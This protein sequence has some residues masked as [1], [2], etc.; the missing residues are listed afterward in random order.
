M[1]QNKQNN[2]QDSWE[3]GFDKKIDEWVEN[4]NEDSIIPTVKQFIK[5]TL[6]E[7]EE[8]FKFR[9]EQL[10]KERH[11]LCEQQIKTTLEELEM[12]INKIKEVVA[13]TYGTDK[14]SSC[15]DD[16]INIIK[17]TTTKLN[18]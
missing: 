11:R 17:N 7:Q 16:C 1:K 18:H 14:Y 6:L 9:Q 5:A 12:E 3:I 15:Y 13:N 8:D 2:K 10:T 4:S